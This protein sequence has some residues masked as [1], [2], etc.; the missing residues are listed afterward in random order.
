MRKRDVSSIFLAAGT[1]IGGGTIAL[2]M[3]F[4]KVGVIPSLAIMIFIWLLNYYP[5][6]AGAELNLRS[7]RGLSLGELGKTFSGAGAQA[8]GE[9]VVKILSYASLTIHLC[10]SSSILQKLLEE[11]FHCGISVL[12]IETCIALFGAV[13]LLFPFKVIS[14][15]NNVMFTALILM[16]LVLLGTIFR[17]VDF[18][19]IPWTV[20]A[21]ACDWLSV[22]P[23]M[24]AAYGYQLILH[25]L[26]DYC[27]KEPAALRKSV[28]FGSLIPT[29]VYMLWSSSSLSVV[30]SSN[31]DF[32]SQMIAGK[33][34]VGSFV[35]ELANASSLPNFQM[36]VWLISI[37][38]IMTS[39]VGVGLG[40]AETLN[41]T[42]QKRT[43]SAGVRKVSASIMTILPAYI[44]AAN[45]P[46]AFIKIL[47]FAGALFVVLG[48]LLPVYLLFKNG[49]QRLQIKELKKWLLMLCFIAGIAVM[50]AEIFIN[51]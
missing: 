21:S 34:E 35:R 23:V 33:A 10:G 51:N 26:R 13:L 45:F 47:G 6:L 20:N 40:L 7:E 39:F 36:L 8:M 11:Y 44:V 2:P 37:L 22:C 32:F 25:T 29:L 30:F 3:V 1:C 27:G 28:F 49:M 19:K 41:F 9:I 5:S 48:I 42:L 43:E 15:L 14:A 50:A 4:A 31:P 16:F 18:D 17:L 12:A 46:G 24:F 38:A